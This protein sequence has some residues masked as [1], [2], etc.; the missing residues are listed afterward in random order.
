MNEKQMQS[1]TVS[2]GT[3]TLVHDGVWEKRVHA[4]WY[5]KLWRFFKKRNYDT[6]TLGKKTP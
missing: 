1:G 2:L 3:F 6:H 5:I 4:P